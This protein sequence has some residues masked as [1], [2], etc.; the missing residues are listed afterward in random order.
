MIPTGESKTDKRVALGCV[1]LMFMLTLFQKSYPFT[2]LALSVVPLSVL[3]WR[4]NLFY[5]RKRAEHERI[6]AY[7]ERPESLDQHHIVNDVMHS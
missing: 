6:I 3:L 4:I 7:W 5:R 2:V 1:V